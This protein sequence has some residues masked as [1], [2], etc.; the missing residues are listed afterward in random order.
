MRPKEHRFLPQH[1]RI[2]HLRSLSWKVSKTSRLL[3]IRYTVYFHSCL[4]INECREW[5]K[6]TIQR[7]NEKVRCN[8][9]MKACELRRSMEVWTPRSNPTI[10]P[11]PSL[12]YLTACSTSINQSS[13]EFLLKLKGKINITME[14]C[15]LIAPSHLCRRLRIVSLFS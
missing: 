15:C 1:D 13:S 5:T 14:T 12:N 7:K 4:W 10:R 9:N 8:K 3:T 2:Q 11:Y 6:R